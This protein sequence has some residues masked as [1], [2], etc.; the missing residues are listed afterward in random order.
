MEDHSAGRGQRA[1]AI[2]LYI[3]EEKSAQQEQQPH[4]D[5]C[6]LEDICKKNI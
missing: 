5:R 1:S 2:V 4:C 3:M 6:C